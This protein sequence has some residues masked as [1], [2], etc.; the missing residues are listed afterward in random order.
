MAGQKK[1]ILKSRKLSTQE[2]K[3]VARGLQRATVESVG[4]TKIMKPLS[5]RS[6]ATGK[7]AVVFR[8][9]RVLSSLAGVAKS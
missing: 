2:A 1:L 5:L 4:R 7:G 3:R 6:T 9:S 8:A